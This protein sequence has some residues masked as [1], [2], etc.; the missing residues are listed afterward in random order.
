MKVSCLSNTLVRHYCCGQR[1]DPGLNRIMRSL[2]N[3]IQT[4]V[5]Y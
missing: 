5:W 2:A 1:R 4:F 3:W